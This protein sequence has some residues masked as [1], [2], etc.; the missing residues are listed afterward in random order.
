MAHFKK[1]PEKA[2]TEKMPKKKNTKTEKTAKGNVFCCVQNALNTEC[3]LSF[4]CSRD[5][6][7]MENLRG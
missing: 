5:Q 1:K 2:Q 3:K 6:V 7:I 4:I